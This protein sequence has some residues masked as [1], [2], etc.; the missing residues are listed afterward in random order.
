MVRDKGGG[1]GRLG[2][3]I[4]I[5]IYIEKWEVQFAVILVQMV[6]VRVF[7]LPPSRLP[8]IELAAVI[9]CLD[10]KAKPIV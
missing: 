5:Y 8:S 2:I 9:S 6:M 7:R 4:H 10:R 1:L 3:K